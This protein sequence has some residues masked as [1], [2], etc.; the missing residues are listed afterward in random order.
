ML[1]ICFKRSSPVDIMVPWRQ[2]ETFGLS[3]NLEKLCPVLL[4]SRV[5]YGI[6][7]MKNDI[8]P[9]LL[10]EMNKGR[11][12]RIRW[13]YMSVTH[14]CEAGQFRL[15]GKAKEDRGGQ[16]RRSVLHFLRL[17]EAWMDCCCNSR[18]QGRETFGSVR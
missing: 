14:D 15:G 10:H 11:A 7:C 5:M 4:I 13:A 1:Q 8:Y 6:A 16:Q 3:G 17:E 9:F 2:M 18:D 12:H